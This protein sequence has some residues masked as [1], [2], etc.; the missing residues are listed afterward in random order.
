LKCR[1][2]SATEEATSVTEKTSIPTEYES[3]KLSVLGTV[4]ELT[5]ADCV[6]KTW[7]ASDGHMMMG[8]S[9]TCVSS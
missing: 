5:L 9:I 3:P 1:N 2:R 6:D 4:Y 7:G 8:V